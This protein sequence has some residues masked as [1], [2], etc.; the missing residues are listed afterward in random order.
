MS[1]LGSITE[2][3]KLSSRKGLD[4]SRRSSL[5]DLY[6]KISLLARAII[7]KSLAVVEKHFRVMKRTNFYTQGQQHTARI[8]CTVWLL[9]SCSPNVTLAAPKA[10]GAMAP[11]TTTSPR[12]LALPRDNGPADG[13]ST[14]AA[15]EPGSY[16]I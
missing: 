7:N 4:L 8:L 9:A 10:K 3:H 13:H 11:A 6:T 2:N 1:L 14:P 5:L 16:A 15:H 12:A